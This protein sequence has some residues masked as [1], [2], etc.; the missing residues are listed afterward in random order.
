[1]ICFKI[2]KFISFC[3]ISCAGNLCIFALQSSDVVMT[4]RSVIKAMLE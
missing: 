2:D 4:L 1:M 3:N